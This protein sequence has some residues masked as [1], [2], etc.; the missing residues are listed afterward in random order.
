MFKTF[1]VLALAVSCIT[2][3][4]LPAPTLN[5]TLLDLADYFQ[6]FWGAFNLTTQ[7]AATCF[8]GISANA[9][10]EQLGVNYQL[11]Q[12]FV[13]GNHS[14]FNSLFQQFLVLN[15]TTWLPLNCVR[16]SSEFA[17]LVSA[18]GGNLSDPNY[19]VLE[20]L[21]YQADWP[22]WILAF[23]PTYNALLAGS[24]NSAG[25][26]F[27]P[28][29]TIT[30]TNSTEAD[31]YYNGFKAF[32]NG[33]WYEVNLTSPYELSNCYNNSLAQAAD[34]FY[35]Y[36]S[37]TVANST[38]AN[39]VNNTNT[40]FNGTGGQYL[41]Q[42]KIINVC[43]EATN[44]Q[45][46]LTQ[47]LGIDVHSDEFDTGLMTWMSAETE[48]YYGLMNAM[49]QAFESNSSLGAGVVMGELYYVVA[50]YILN[51]PVSA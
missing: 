38:L 21:Y 32:Q 29:F 33:I 36:W 7:L 1:I 47:A 8:N 30:Q 10:F 25:Y 17:Q 20:D 37:Q 16:S 41:A 48:T 26:G 13:A 4:S 24:Y 6:G 19:G 43:L 40:Y 22:E 18:A 42:V 51:S 49:Y 12:A 15:V 27:G 44:D 2:S 23:A 39:V 35:Y 31:I 45:A 5:G 50:Q 28:L 14:A 9:Y 34:A 3:Q 46:R 11:A